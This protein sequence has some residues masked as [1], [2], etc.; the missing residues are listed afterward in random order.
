[1]DESCLSFETVSLV[2][3]KSRQWFA[4]ITFFNSAQFH[5]VFNGLGHIG[6]AK[7]V[8][9]QSVTP[10]QH[11]PRRVPVAF[12]KDVERK[13]LELEEKGIITKQWSPQHH[14]IFRECYSD[15]SDT[16]CQLVTNLVLR[17]S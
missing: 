17:C 2:Q 8:V 9:D 7:I 4:D 1:L 12:R 15:F 3:T 11:L 13:I 5:D 14:A 16:I 6:D 10:V